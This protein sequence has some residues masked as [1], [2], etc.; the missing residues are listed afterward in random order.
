ML[1]CVCANIVFYATGANQL[2]EEVVQHGRHTVYHSYGNKRPSIWPAGQSHLVTLVLVIL[3]LLRD[4]FSNYL[5]RI[6]SF[7]S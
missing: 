4:I 5:E 6:D 7:P 3:Y 2:L 1:V